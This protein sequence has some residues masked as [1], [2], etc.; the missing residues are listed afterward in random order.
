MQRRTSAADA[1]WQN[2][3]AERRGGILQVILP[4]MDAEESISDYDQLAIALQNATQTKIVFGK[5]AHIRGS[6]VSDPNP[7]THAVALSQLP[8]GIPFPSDLATR[9]TARKV[10]AQFDNDQ[11][12]FLP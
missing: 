1:Q 10:F 5:C 4:K 2:A 8:E 12:H 6:I 9:E 7:A 11:R 3:R